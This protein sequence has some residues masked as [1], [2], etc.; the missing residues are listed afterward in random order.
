MSS[1][2]SDKY[3]RSY[4]SNDLKILDKSFILM[5]VEESKLGF[6]YTGKC[7]KLAR[8]IIKK[9]LYSFKSPFKVI[10]S[11]YQLIILHRSVL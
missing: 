8:E 5:E 9:T 7:E 2:T 11:D 10:Y 6:L 4:I 3:L 1:N